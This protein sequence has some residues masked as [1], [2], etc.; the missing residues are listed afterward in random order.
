MVKKEI[1]N[2]RV[3]VRGSVCCVCVFERERERER[4]GRCV[5]ASVMMRK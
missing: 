4:E 5:S 1:P 3:R 2:E